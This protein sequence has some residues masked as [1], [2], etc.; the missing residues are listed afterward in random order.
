[1]RRTSQFGSKLG[2][3]RLDRADVAGVPGTLHIYLRYGPDMESAGEAGHLGRIWVARLGRGGS[4]M[5]HGCT[6]VH[7]NF[8]DEN[9]YIGIYILFYMAV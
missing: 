9:S 1:M 2:L 5:G 6:D 8:C 4:T 7:P 3:V